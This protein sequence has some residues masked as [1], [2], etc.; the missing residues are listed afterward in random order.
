M[1]EVK[2]RKWLKTKEKGLAR[3]LILY[4]VILG[5]TVFFIITHLFFERDRA[6]FLSASIEKQSLNI[7]SSIFFGLIIAIASWYKG[8]RL[9][10]K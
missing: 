9:E 1:N 2:Y 4:G 8:L 6:A 3:Y 5:G 7:I 10:V